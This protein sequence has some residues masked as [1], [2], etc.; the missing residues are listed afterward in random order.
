M[1][2]ADLIVFVTELARR[3]FVRRQVLAHGFVDASRL[4]TMTRLRELCVQSARQAGLLCAPALSDAR[5]S[6]IIRRAAEE[7][8]KEIG[9]AGHLGLLSASALADTLDTLVETL[10]PFG[11]DAGHIQEWL[12][13]QESA[14]GKLRQLGALYAQY[15]KRLDAANAADTRDIN[16]AV[17]RLL[18]GPRDLWP[19]RLRTLEGA[20]VFRAIRWLNPFEEAFIA[21]LKKQLGDARV[22]IASALPPAHA[23]K[24]QDRLA[25]RI[26]SD[27]MMGAGDE[28]TAWAENLTDA[29][30]MADPNLAMD[31]RDRID[32]SRSVGQYGEIED[33][34]R[35]IRWEI[36]CRR[37]A[38][39]NIAL[40]VRNIG[41][42]A[43]AIT[44]VFARF[45]IPCFFRRGLPASSLPLVKTFLSLLSLPLGMERDRFCSLL[46]SPVLKWNGFATDEERQ[47]AAFEIQASGVAP[48]LSVENIERR[49]KAYFQSGESRLPAARFPAVL[50]A[51]TQGIKRLRALS[52]AAPLHEHARNALAFIRDFRAERNAASAGAD[53]ADNLRALELTETTLSEIEQATMDDAAPRPYAEL[54]DLLQNSLDNETVPPGRMDENGVWVLNP[55]DAAGLRFNVVLIA[56][57]NEGVFP[58]LPR[59]DSVFSDP[60]RRQVRQS[61]RE[62]GV[63]LPLWALPESTVRGIQESTLFLISLGTARTNLVLSYIACDTDGRELIPGDFFRSLW[64]LAGWPADAS[65]AL[66]A[67]DRWRIEKLGPDSHWARHARKQEVTPVYRRAPMPGESFL[68]TVPLPLCRAADEARQRVT[69]APESELRTLNGPRRTPHDD[70]AR[71]IA[72]NLRIEQSRERF[73]GS[74]ADSRPAA[75]PYCGKLADGFARES[76]AQWLKRH[77][78]FSPTALETLA[79]CRYRFLL[80]R[81]MNLG[82]LRVQGDEPDIMDRGKVIH[83]ILQLVYKALAGETEGIDASVLKP[84][85]ALCKPR[86]W[87]AKDKAGNWSLAHKP[88]RPGIPLVSFDAA[89]ANDYG[90]FAEALAD[91]CFK[92]A[93]ASGETMRLGDPGIWATEKPK[94]RRIVRNYAALDAEFAGEEK[95]YPALFELRFGRQFDGSE[96]DSPAL[97]L[98]AAGDAVAF[99][100]QI[101]RLD[102][103]F[104]ENGKLSKLLVIDYKGV[105]RGGLKE[106]EYAEEIARNLNCQLPIYAFAAQQFFFGR[107]NDAPLNERTEAVY[108]IQDRNYDNMRK[109]FL[110]RRIRLNFV[111]QSGSGL[112]DG[113]LAQLASNVR[114]VREADFSVDP[115][116]C[117]YCDFQHICRVDVNAL[118][119]AKEND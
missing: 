11:N 6:V 43:D 60:E 68:A 111:P 109:Q 29:L 45:G 17:L 24:I 14:D 87:A 71:T 81:M 93:E 114:R 28:W 64:N 26:R 90:D 117:R 92:R 61:L 46:Q 5:R 100:G 66:N 91:F 44:H 73:F 54:L 76:S 116:D 115:L 59:Q 58:S 65:I 57:L 23:E 20:L 104:D 16:A 95:R 25:S 88:P 99:H 69:H 102:L 31:N 108:H 118:T 41:D 110:N 74:P 62:K 52:A 47:R 18:N 55:F 49:L 50:R 3:Q 67:Y 27:V 42:Y 2:R 105:S 72:E 106:E 77:D 22:K 94:I 119:A 96:P 39:E 82:A 98:Q 7:A 48:R 35:R 83:Q 30:E 34:A 75:E 103:V 84:Y 112:M 9:D 79:K 33:L 10:S 78:E 40:I 12:L 97:L 51:L 4:A 1:Y 56:G 70:V 21:A 101:D 38:P 36:D 53:V 32:F 15:R 85:A 19:H 8:K 113:F 107:H 80:E 63:D 89:D 13:A 37:V 86:V